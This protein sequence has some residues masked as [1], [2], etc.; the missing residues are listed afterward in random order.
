MNDFSSTTY[1]LLKNEI[2]KTN[3]NVAK[4]AEDINTV[5]GSISS[6]TDRV[7]TLETAVANFPIPLKYFG[8]KST[9]SA[10]QAE[11]VDLTLPLDE[12]ATYLIIA[13]RPNS[14]ASDSNGMYIA[15]TGSGNNPSSVKTI[16][17]STYFSS[18][19]IDSDKVLTGTAIGNYATY[20]VYKVITSMG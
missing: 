17:A 14:S 20:Y 7:G 2:N 18:F 9:T 1:A 5:N 19:A 12:G 3:G 13:S 6:L 8:L 10:S 15:R 16:I 11:P 4:N